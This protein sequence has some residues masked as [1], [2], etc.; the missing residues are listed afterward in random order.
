M[1]KLTPKRNIMIF[2]L[3]WISVFSMAQ[4][5]V[6][7]TYDQA[8]NREQ[9]IIDMTTPQTVNPSAELKGGWL[10]SI[11]VQLSDKD[12]I[13]YPNPTKGLLKVEIP[14]FVSGTTSMLN[15]FDVTGKKVLD[16]K[17]IQPMNIL[18]LE[19]YKSGTYILRLCIG[20]ES[21]EWKILKN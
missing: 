2:A 5:K 15:I 18:N 10:D 7:F 13:V 3:M 9:R 12:I 21:F 6:V 8:G 19:G 1:R 20:N 16:M 11:N 4:S 17:N 14:E